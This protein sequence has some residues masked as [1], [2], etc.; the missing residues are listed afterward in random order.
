MSR[1][2]RQQRPGEGR[3][4]RR[5]AGRRIF[6]WG[7]AVAAHVLVGVLVL[8]ALPKPLEVFEPSAVIVDLVPRPPPPAPPV[9]A[10]EKPAPQPAPERAATPA[11]KAAPAK[12]AARPVHLAI[13]APAPRSLPT[14]PARPVE[15][16][17]ELSAADVAGATTAGS[18]AGSGGSGSGG[19]GRCDMVRRLQEALRRDARVQAAVADAHRAAGG[20]GAAIMVWNGDWVRSGDEE[21]KGLAS[22]RQAIAVDVA[23]APQAC[24]A[25]PVSGLVL[26]S[27][28]DAP[29]SAKLA[30]GA[31]HWRWSDLLFAR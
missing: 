29:G 14:P 4:A 27:L 1:R 30:L 24:R 8:Q 18:G 22:V 20:R 7:V 5:R 17:T 10:P 23:F 21:G 2:I 15:A 6:A 16:P 12:P 31:G 28:N 19:G 11:H 13:R 25:E 9:P 3:A 26:I